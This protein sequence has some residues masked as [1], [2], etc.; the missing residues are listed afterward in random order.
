MQL[1]GDK[2]D[3]KASFKRVIAMLSDMRVEHIQEMHKEFQMTPAW[4]FE[5]L[6]NDTLGL[7]P[8]Q[9]TVVAR[10]EQFKSIS[11]A[12]IE[13]MARSVDTLLKLSEPEH[14]ADGNDIPVT[15]EDKALRM[16][17]SLHHM[18]KITDEDYNKVSDIFHPLVEGSDPSASIPPELLPGVRRLRNLSHLVKEEADVQ[19]LKANIRSLF[20]RANAAKLAVDEHLIKKPIISALG[21]VWRNSKKVSIS[22]DV[23]LGLSVVGAIVTLA[24]PPAI[25]VVGPLILAALLALIVCFI[26]D[27]VALKKTGGTLE[28]NIKTLVE[29]PSDVST[30]DHTLNIITAFVKP[31]NAPANYA[32][33]ANELREVNLGPVAPIVGGAVADAAEAAARSPNRLSG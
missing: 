5:L 1:H 19:R 17:D 2:E 7:S 12:T 16:V 31:E 27:L 29:K 22:K 13:H 18:S 4:F 20:A 14:D 32:K 21:D 8:K 28:P 11:V 15:N 30:V 26:I 3:L 9:R 10:I 25:I 23:L 6:K 33:A 24:F